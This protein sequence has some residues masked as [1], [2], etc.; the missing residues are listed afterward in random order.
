MSWRELG[1]SIPGRASST[2]KGP[3]AGRLGVLKDAQGASVAGMA[4]VRRTMDRHN[5]GEPAGIM[6]GLVGC[7]EEVRSTFSQ[8][9]WEATETLTQGP[10]CILQSSLSLWVQVES[11]FQGG[12][13]S[14][15][16]RPSQGLLHQPRQRGRGQLWR[17][18]GCGRADRLKVDFEFSAFNVGQLEEEGGPKGDTW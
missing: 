16:R 10:V 7:D 13:K 9:Q 5:L 18:Q 17:E 1:K 14:S 8:V 11:R 15:S 2:C 4:G 6:P 3:E 12:E